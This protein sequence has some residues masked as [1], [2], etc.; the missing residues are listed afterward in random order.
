MIMGG[1]VYVPTKVFLTATLV[2]KD[3]DLLLLVMSFTDITILHHHLEEYVWNF[4]QAS[5]P[6]NKFKKMTY[7]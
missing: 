6:S 1:R 5:W 7:R 4:F 3:L 2:L